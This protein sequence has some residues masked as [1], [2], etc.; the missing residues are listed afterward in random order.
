[1]QNI[2]QNSTFLF[3][4]S[5]QLMKGEN[6]NLHINTDNESTMRFINAKKGKKK[7]RKKPKCH[8]DNGSYIFSSLLKK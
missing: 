4:N 5:G 3:K 1:M 8:K 6:D 7:K 2:K